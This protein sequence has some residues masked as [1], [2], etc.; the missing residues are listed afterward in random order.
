MYLPLFIYVFLILS[1]DEFIP[2]YLSIFIFIHPLQSQE[3][4]SDM[5]YYY[6]IINLF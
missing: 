2:I 3:S 6:N 4:E 5:F 1:R